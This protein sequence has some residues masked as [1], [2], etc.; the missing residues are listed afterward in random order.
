MKIGIIQFS[1]EARW[2]SPNLLKHF[3]A[4]R[5]TLSNMQKMG[6]Q[7]NFAPPLDLVRQTNNVPDTYHKKLVFLQTDGCNDD[8]ADT[9]KQIKLL[10]AEG[11]QIIGIAVGKYVKREQLRSYCAQVVD[12]DNYASL[13]TDIT[14]I[15]RVAE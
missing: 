11:C 10:T 9:K 5:K 15:V 6:G 7:T 3:V 4:V 8:D 14:T 1:D 2:E 13:L 12:V